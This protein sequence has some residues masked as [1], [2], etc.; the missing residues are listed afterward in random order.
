M[1]G[2]RKRRLTEAGRPVARIPQRGPRSL[3]RS[4]QH[5]RPLGG[6]PGRSCPLADLA[7][8]LA[9]LWETWRGGAKVPSYLRHEPRSCEVRI[10][11]PILEFHTSEQHPCDSDGPACQPASPV[12][13]RWGL[14]EPGALRSV[15]PLA[16]PT[17]T[18]APPPSV[19]CD[20][21]PRAL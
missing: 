1:A 20:K 21:H 10:P 8:R 16:G 7:A 12:N 15:L 18:S 17:G 4:R 11:T 19:L 6:R 14:A 5:C 2:H 13:K 3:C 9:S